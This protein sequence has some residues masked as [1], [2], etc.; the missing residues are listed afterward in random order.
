MRLRQIIVSF[1]IIHSLKNLDCQSKNKYKVPQLQ[2]SKPT[3]P[4]RTKLESLY[5]RWVP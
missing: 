3:L 2:I 1:I 5:N 4:C